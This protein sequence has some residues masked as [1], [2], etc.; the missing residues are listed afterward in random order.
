MGSNIP[1][2]Q[3]LRVSTGKQPTRSISTS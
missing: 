1:A 3:Y 2:A